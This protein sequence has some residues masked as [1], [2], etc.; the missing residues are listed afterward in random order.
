MKDV[1]ICRNCKHYDFSRMDGCL[2]S[3]K[4]VGLHPVYGF[5]QTTGARAAEFERTSLMPWKCG[6]SGRH[7]TQK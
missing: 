4:Q 5:M 7:F 1:P 3:L 6:P 2:R